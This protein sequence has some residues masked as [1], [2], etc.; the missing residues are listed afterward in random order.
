MGSLIR[1]L[2]GHPTTVAIATFC[3]FAFGLLSYNTL[4]RESAPD[5]QIP[6]VIV[7]TPYVGVSPEDI[8]SI[9][10]VPMENELA[11]LKNVKVMNST[12]AEGISIIVIEFEPDA[13]IED[14]LQ[15][16]RDRVG[17]VR[18]DLPEDVEE[19]S[20]REI[21]FSDIPVVLITLAGRVGGDQLKA[22]AE[23]LQDDLTRV[24]GVLEV[25]LTGGTEREIKVQVIPER[26]AHYGLKMSD[27]TG[28]LRDE[29]V[30][31]PGGNVEVG[32]GNFLLR[33]PG[34][35][36]D[37]KEIEQV[38]IKRIGD[39][40]VFVRDIARVIDGYRTRETYSRMGGRPAVTLAVKKRAGANILD[41][42]SNVK[43][44]SGEHAADWPEAVEY[45]ALGDES[46]YIEQTV[47]DLQN[48]IITALILVV[49]VIIFFMGLRPSLFVAVSIPLS[50]LGGML[51][52][53]LFGFTL[54]MIVL[55]SLILALGMLVDNAIVVVE[56]IY[57]HK[58]MGKDNVRAAIEGTEEVAVAVAASTA[59]TVAAFFPLV[60][61]TGIM[62]EF[63]GF[64]PKTVVIVLVMSLVMAI[65]VLP[66]VVSRF[67]PSEVATRSE[68]DGDLRD[69]DLHWTMGSYRQFLKWSIR[70]RYLSFAS[71]VLMLF[72][73]FGIYAGFN[74]GTEFFPAT[75]PDRA[76]VSIKL[77]EGTDVET[78]DKVVRE[79]EAILAEQDNID[80]FV[81]ETGVSGGGSPLEGAS[82]SPN[83]AR[84]TI[85]FLPDRNSAKPGEQP[86][87]ESS[88]ITVDRLRAMVAEIPGAK[89]GVEPQEMGPPVGKPINVEISGEDYDAIGEVVLKLRRGIEREI[90]GVADLEDNYG[91]GRPEMR[92]RIDRGAAKRVGVSTAQVGNAVRTAIAGSVAT[93]MMDGEE[94][95]DVVVELAPEYREDVQQVLTL[96][97][98]GRE[99][100]SPDTYPVPI[101]TVASYE[102]VGGS[103]GIN[104]VDQDLVVTI[105]GDVAEGFNENAVRAAVQAF[106]AAYDLPEGMAYSLTGA[107]EE[108]EEAAFFLTRA[109][110]IAV[111][112]ILLV[113]VTQFDSI[114]TPAIIIAT[115]VLSLIGV[116]WGLMVTGTPFGII[117]TGLGVISLAGVVVNNAIVLLDYV[118]QLLDRGLTIEEALVEAGLTRFRPVLLTAITTALGLVPMAIGVSFDF[119]R[120]KLLVGGTS[121]QFWGPMAVAVIFGLAFAT[122]LTLVMVPTLYSINE[123]LRRVLGRLFRGRAA[124]V[125]ASALLAAG[126]AGGLAWSPPAQALTLQE[127]WRAAEENDLSL[128]IAREDAV[129]AGT[130]RGRAWATS[131]PRISASAGYIIN[132]Q[133][134]EF[135]VDPFLPVRVVTG[136]AIN[137]LLQGQGAPPIIP[138]RD[139][140]GAEEPGVDD[141][142]P[143]PQSVVIQERTFAQAD[144]QVSQRLFDA[145]SIPGL[146][147]AYRLHEAAQQDLR[148]AVQQSRASVAQAYY[149]L[150]SAERGLA[151]SQNALEI[152]TAQLDLAERQVAAGLADRR[153]VV[154]AR[155]G[156]SQ[157]ERDLQSAREQLLDAQTGFE[158]LTGLPGEGLQLPEPFPIPEGV[159]SALATARSSRPDLQA[160]D[161]RVA[162]ARLERLAWDFQWMPTIDAAGSLNWTENTGFNDQNVTW[163]IALTA[164]WQ[165]FDGGLRMAERRE[166]ASRARAASYVADLTLQQAERDIRLAFE[167]HRRAEEALEAV[168]D[169]IALA[170]EGLSLA[171][172]SFEAGSATWLELEQARLQLQSTQLSELQER[173]ARDLAAIDLLLRTG[174]L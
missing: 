158:L 113:L 86:R 61:W 43:R 118:E 83:Q 54:N 122:V 123:D 153:A 149:A 76:I 157:G 12:S 27:I 69:A 161:L 98:P 138:T 77:P 120:L 39:R 135:P 11:S 14:A 35:F 148:G 144:V 9:I 132:N 103:T 30:N 23:D 165:L 79:V 97:L 124:E 106:V 71:V 119:G 112:L 60:F 25:D 152:A 108:Q 73:T 53:D 121:A 101:S 38:A 52:L 24:P 174:T 107:S 21:S 134:I 139:C 18:P 82:A 151:V 89:I 44:V 34:K 72:A 173:T 94:E 51:L 111:A 162:A 40:P 22:L 125:A 66:V 110:F 15:R 130:V 146:V 57:R 155:L 145:S 58:E 37:A 114:T 133:E 47:S 84:I 17:R 2:V 75:E 49:G 28:A 59:T 141:C 19:P 6:V 167:A 128:A 96:R 143:A 88:Q 137:G 136:P 160:A 16:V 99:D 20:I 154:Q 95:I 70:N 85:D 56:N 142:L 26:L 4:P 81:A 170:Q 55:F 169:E 1:W 172:R 78:T 5:I 109:F 63:M 80:T 102:F 36:V 45:R 31:I 3:V 126:L 93:T 166:A 163:R 62:G 129:Q 117:M 8:E 127:A 87:A 168:G 171:E 50:M 65:C 29:N 159:E 10:T 48:N 7:T 116:L 115:V 13:V 90:P 104:H 46:K 67:M 68:N 147:S 32:R 41:V 131:L 164:T 92:L 105:S 150:L 100:T 140:E 156:V 33:V 74:H 42:V 64:L 91:V